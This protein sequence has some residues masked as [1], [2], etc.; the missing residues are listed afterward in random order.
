MKAQPFCLEAHGN[1]NGHCYS[2]KSN[3]SEITVR[4]GKYNLTFKFYVNTKIWYTSEMLLVVDT[5]NNTNFPDALEGKYI[6]L[7]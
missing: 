7:F 4:W 2:S 6:C 3:E 5:H 1:V